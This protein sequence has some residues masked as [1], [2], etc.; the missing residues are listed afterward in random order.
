MLRSGRN[1]QQ[2]RT[3]LLGSLARL[4][5]FC[6]VTIVGATQYPSAEVIDQ[7]I[8]TQLT[9]R[10]MLRVASGEQVNVCLG[11]GYGRTVSPTSIGP[12]ERGGLWIV[13]LP[14]APEPV[15]G[16][17]HWVSD[18]DVAARVAATR[19]LT[20]IPGPGI[21][22]QRTRPHRGGLLMTRHLPSHGA[23]V[24][25]T[26]SVVMPEGYGLPST[27]TPHT[28]GP[29]RMVTT[30]IGSGAPLPF[31]A[32]SPIG[33]IPA[34]VA[35][36][37]VIL[38]A[39]VVALLVVLDGHPQRLH[40]M[41]LVLGALA[42]WCALL[43]APVAIRRVSDRLRGRAP[44]STATPSST[45]GRDTTDRSRQRDDS[46]PQTR[47]TSSPSVTQPTTVP[48]PMDPTAIETAQVQRLSHLPSE[49]SSATEAGGGSV[50]GSR[51]PA[52]PM[53]RGGLGNDWQ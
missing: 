48:T 21:H 49:P 18:H 35:M 42:A 12:T 26:H 5:R 40:L 45:T 25:P 4:A 41:A 14:N 1:G 27:H 33:A 19:H 43:A 34:L 20:P 24:A 13:G 15:R 31:A 39:T 44:T 3:G 9:I 29:D 17:A 7:Q 22:H 23:R 47:P 10:I 53:A 50:S 8:R 16:R 30:D 32:P 37:T 38:T 36:A 11:Q 46:P 2:V 6:G 28:A 52:E 51:R